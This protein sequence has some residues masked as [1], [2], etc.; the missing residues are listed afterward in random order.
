MQLCFVRMT[1]MRQAFSSCGISALKLWSAMRGQAHKISLANKGHQILPFMDSIC[2]KNQHCTS[3]RLGLKYTVN[4]TGKRIHAYGG[5]GDYV[6]SKILK[7]KNQST[8]S[9]YPFLS[10]SAAV[11][12]AGTFYIWLPKG[13]YCAVSTKPAVLTEC[14]GKYNFSMRNKK[15][16]WAFPK[17]Q[18]FPTTRLYAMLTN[19]WRVKSQWLS[20]PFS[21]REEARVKAL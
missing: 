9:M 4:H 14:A 17:P 15:V 16:W 6:S 5:G 1:C 11:F 3:L 2:M 19:A 8:T 21:T 10:K 13:L 12:L 20:S 7:Q 18:P